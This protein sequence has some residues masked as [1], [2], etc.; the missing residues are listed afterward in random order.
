[1]KTRRDITG[2]TFGRLTAVSRAEN[3]G[4]SSFWL[5]RCECGN[6]K[7]INRCHAVRLKT[8]SCGCLNRDVLGRALKTHGGS[9][10]RLYVLWK[11]MRGRC[12]NPN[13]ARYS[14]YGGRGIG[15]EFASFADFRD[16]SMRNGYDDSKTIDRIDNDRGYSPENCR[17]TDVVGQQRNKR[18]THWVTV[19]GRRVS[20]AEAAELLGVKYTTLRRRLNN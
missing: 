6:L 13:D 16:W 18:N 5:F 17:W 12:N 14:S 4:R 3:R 8:K 20:M 19:D 11:A 15:I 2:M 1:M 7:E 9:G 10:T